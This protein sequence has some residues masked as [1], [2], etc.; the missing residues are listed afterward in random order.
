MPHVASPPPAQLEAVLSA[1][2]FDA[3]VRAVGGDRRSAA[4]LYAWN[5]RLAAALL[6]PMHF[7]EISARNVVHE[8]LTEV[9]GS[10]WP[11]NQTFRGSLPRPSR[12]YKPREDL[13]R[14]AGPT[15]RLPTGKIVAELKFVFWQMMFTSRHQSRIWDQRLGRLLPHA[16]AITGTTT[17]TDDDLRR[18]VY[19][20]LEVIREVRNRV[21]HHEPIH[22]RPDLEVDLQRTLDLIKLR[23]RVTGL[24]VHSIEDVSALLAARP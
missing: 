18:R 10:H 24:W 15:Q 8:A 14:T 6:L 12:G 3:Y 9:Y 22:A 19:A 17:L 13:E 11:W 5:A 1:P 20:D 2:R 4:E 21:A 23:C 16:P 7:A